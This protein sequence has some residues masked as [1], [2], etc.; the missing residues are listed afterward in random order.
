[1]TP[2]R[3]RERHFIRA[4]KRV[5]LARLA[6]QISVLEHGALL[7]YQ[8]CNEG[9]WKNINICLVAYN[10]GNRPA[11]RK[12]AEPTTL[13]LD[14]QSVK[15]SAMA[16]AQIGFDG[17]KR[18]KGRKRFVLIDTSGAAVATCVLPANAHDGQRALAWWAKLAH[19]PLLGQVQ[20]VFI[21]GGFRGECVKKIAKLYQIEVTVP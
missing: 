19:R 11:V 16:T 14:S 1:M 2:G 5:W 15:N 18:I 4:Q 6:R 20:R 7:L 17:D 3:G 8:V 13:I 21:D 10:Q 12:K 9:V